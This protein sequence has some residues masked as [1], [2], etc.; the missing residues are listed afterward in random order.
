M[1]V[2]RGIE[3]I[4]DQVVFQARKRLRNY[5]NLL[6]EE[7]ANYCRK[8]LTHIADEVRAVLQSYALVT[9][10]SYQLEERF[11][12]EHRDRK[13]VFAQELAV[14][15]FGEVLV[16][17]L[18]RDFFTFV[19]NI[20]PKLKNDHHLYYKFMRRYYPEMASIPVPNLFGSIW[21]PQLII[22]LRRA[23]NQLKRRYT[24]DKQQLGWVNFENWILQ[25]HR[26]MDYKRQFLELDSIF[27]DNAVNKYF[28]L[29]QQGVKHVYDG[30][31]F[32]NFLRTGKLIVS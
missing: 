2:E 24:R 17:T 29:V 22:E 20:N 30:N 8:G 10:T 3:V 19:T 4:V 21:A 18:D 23:I 16:P 14:R 9:P 13:Y 12:C 7:Y 15:S 5:E 27:D 26:L 32:F 31:E 11:H 6:K 28:D 25:E 1:T